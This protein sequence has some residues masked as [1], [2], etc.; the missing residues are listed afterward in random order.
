MESFLKKHQDRIVG[1]LAGYD[2]MRFRGTLRS[3]AYGDGFE[4]FLAAH[5]VR[6]GQF[7]KGTGAQLVF[8]KNSCI[9]AASRYHIQR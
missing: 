1:V 8:R 9:P 5:G 2:R 3:I 6:Y 4:A 7:R